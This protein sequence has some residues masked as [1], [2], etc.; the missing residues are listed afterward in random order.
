MTVSGAAATGFTVTYSGAS[1]GHDV[2]NLE[3]VERGCACFTSVQETNHGGA[4]DSFRLNYDGNVSAP[5]TNGANYTT[6]DIHAALAAPSSGGRTPPLSPHSAAGS[7]TT[8]L[9][10]HVR[11]TLQ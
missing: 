1:A 4:Y 10:G 7:S 5:I 3:L 9:P 8:R 6:E 2:P 11:G